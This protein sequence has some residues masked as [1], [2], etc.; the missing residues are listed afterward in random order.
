L[1]GGIV[2]GGAQGGYDSGGGS[3]GSIYLTA[4]TLAGAG[5]ISADGGNGS[6]SGGGGGGGR[7]AI[8]YD[9]DTFSG[10]V[11]AS[12]GAGLSPGGTGTIFYLRTVDDLVSVSLSSTRHDLATGRTSML[13]TITNTSTT[14]IQGPVWVVIQS[15]TDPTVTLAGSSGTTADGYLYIDVTSLLGDGRLDP[16]ESISTRLSFNNSLRRQFEF[17][18]TIRGVF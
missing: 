10:T 17:T 11:T 7:I 13:M 2:C 1:D 6:E 15:I 14:V 4:G 12:G 5:T 18:Y 8:Y 16:G 3:G 9:T